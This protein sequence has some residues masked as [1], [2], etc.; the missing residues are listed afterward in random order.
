[1]IPEMG[2]DE[3]HQELQ[4]LQRQSLCAGHTTIVRRGPSSS[5]T[6]RESTRWAAR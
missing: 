1:M 4:T 6:A 2:N 5:M 3:I